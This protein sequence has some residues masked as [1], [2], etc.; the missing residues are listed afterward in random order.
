MHIS[1]DN[2][3]VSLFSEIGELVLLNFLVILTSLPV[4]TAGAALTSG[5]EILLRRDDP[6]ERVVTTTFFRKFAANFRSVTPVWMLLLLGILLGGGDLIYALFI[7]EELRM[8]FLC[9]SIAVL[10]VVI[11]IGFW[12]FPL[13]ASFENKRTA[14][15]ENAFRM[16]FLQFPRTIRMWAVWVVPAYFTLTYETILKYFGWIWILCGISGLMYLSA[17]TAAGAFESRQ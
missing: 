3:A 13:F 11:S 5:Y 16:T 2:K 6:E 9:F 17:K 8:F 4:F 14:H 1:S 7:A 12:I 10:F 15:L